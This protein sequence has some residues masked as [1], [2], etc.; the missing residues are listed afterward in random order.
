MKTL[1]TISN[2]E[3]KISSNKSA[4]TF[5]IRTSAAKYRTTRMSQDEFRSAQ[6]WTGQDWQEY[7]KSSDYYKV[8]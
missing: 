2:R 7:L 8:N 1:T 6:N 3:F 5:T 4:R